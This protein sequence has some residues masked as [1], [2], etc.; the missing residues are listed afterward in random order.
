[1]SNKVSFIIQLKDQFGRNAQ[2]IRR[3]FSDIKKAA[4]K[5]KRSVVGFAKKLKKSFR[6]IKKESLAGAAAVSAAIALAIGSAIKRSADV[7]DAMAD[8]ARVTSMTRKELGVFEN[9]LEKT[10]ESLGKTKIGLAQMAFEGGKLG[11]AQKDM[12]SF[13]ITVTKTAT[14]FD[15]LDS[16]AGRAIGSI[17]AKMGLAKNSTIELLDSVNFLADNTTASGS[18]MIEVLERTAGTFK[19]LKIDP[20]SAA[21]FAGVADQL[22]VSGQ[23]AAS[24]LNMFFNRLQK[25]RGMTTKLLANP[26]ATVRKELE[27]IAKLSPES[28]QRFIQSSFGDEAGRF[29]KKMVANLDLFDKAKKIAFSPK[30]IGSMT[31]EMDNQLSRSS[32]TFKRFSETSKN[33]FESIGDAFKPLAASM[34]NAMQPVIDSFGGF[35]KNNPVLVQTAALFFGI[36]VAITAVVGV[37]GVLALL[38]GALSLPIL[39]FVGIV[40][41]LATAITVISVNFDKFKSFL[42]FG[43]DKKSSPSAPLQSGSGTING[44]ITVSAAQGSKVDST[45]I[46]SSSNGLNLGMNMAA[47]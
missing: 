9:M 18:R 25:K 23:L 26:L 32:T 7:E 47:M 35:I 33:T 6:S 17:Q 28:Q 36:A 13:I 45:A 1:M 15:M 27:K 19:L 29:V 5:A 10:S 34:A 24:G 30:A 21:T 22:E 8:I 3:Q 46:K 12:R 37:V 4:D 44:Q 40:A 43:D 2:K 20:K 42:G 14:A 11:I 31:R 16:E 38:F 39:A 41:A